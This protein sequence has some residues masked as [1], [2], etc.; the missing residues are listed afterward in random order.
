MIHGLSPSLSRLQESPL[1]SHPRELNFVTI[2]AERFGTA[3]G[4]VTRLGGKTLADR[5]ACQGL[6]SVLSSPGNRCHMSQNNPGTLH[7]LA[8]HLKSHSRGRKRP[9][10]SFLL[11]NFIGGIFNTLS[12]RNN[13]FTY[14]L[15]RLQS[16]FAITVILWCHEKCLGR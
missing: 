12:R 11:P 7:C 9:I 16:G 5:L 15:V 2:F 8:T 10:E 13:D 4:S 1:S 3:D 14:N 6:F